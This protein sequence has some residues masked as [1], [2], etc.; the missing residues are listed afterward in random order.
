VSEL[1][2][3]HLV[4]ELGFLISAFGYSLYQTLSELAFSQPQRF[5]VSLR[6][7]VFDHQ[8][9]LWLLENIK[10]KQKKNK[11]KLKNK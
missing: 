6:K 9:G 10:K 5:R 11:P 1:C 2:S 7:L 4:S 8:L 3:S